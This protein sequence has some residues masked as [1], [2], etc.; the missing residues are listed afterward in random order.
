M[1]STLRNCVL[2]WIGLLLLAASGCQ[3]PYHADQGALF[4]GLTG[5]GVGALVGHA[6]GNT[7]AGAAIGA[8]VGA[9]TGAAVGSSLDEIEARNRAE[10]EARLGRPPAAGAVTVEEVIAMTQS[11]VNEEVIATHVRNNGVARPL[12]TNDLIYLQNNQVSA[13]VIRAM[14]EPPVQRPV[15]V[16]GPPPPVVVHEYYGPHCGYDYWGHHH[17]HHRPRLGVGFSYHGH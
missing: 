10:I 1:K 2:P 9:L 3:S 15:V 7:G 6:T 11:G 13:R 8:G 4:G 12:G 14:Q 17:Y 16:Q 5:A